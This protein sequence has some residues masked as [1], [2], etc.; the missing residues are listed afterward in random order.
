MRAFAGC[1]ENCKNGVGE[2]TFNGCRYTVVQMKILAN[3]VNV[4]AYTDY[5]HFPQVTR[6]ILPSAAN[7]QAELLIFLFLY[8]LKSQLNCNSRRRTTIENKNVQTSL[9]LPVESLFSKSS[10]YASLRWAL[11]CTCSLVAL[12]VLVIML[13]ATWDYTK[14]WANWGPDTFRRWYSISAPTAILHIFPWLKIP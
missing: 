4:C 3:Q 5:L 2:S 8:L 6:G 12:P 11:W 7:Y 9:I 14:S 1:I 10:I 13:S